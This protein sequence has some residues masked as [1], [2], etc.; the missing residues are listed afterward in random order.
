M[1][2]RKA[3]LIG[4]SGLVGGYCLEYLLAEELYEEV[5]L[6]V[7]KPVPVAHEKTIQRVTD[8]DQLEQL[9]DF[10]RVD[11][12]FCCLGSTLK[13]A[14]SQQA[15]YKVDF[16]YP[17][18][19]AQRA[20]QSGASQF[21]LVSAL[22]ANP[23]SEIFY[24]RVKGEVEAAVKQIPF[25]SVQIFRPSLLM[26]ARAEKRLGE[27]LSMALF[28]PLAW[29]LAGPWRKYRPIEAR[30]VA[31]AMVRVARQSLG[32]FNVYESDRIQ[33]LYDELSGFDI[34]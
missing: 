12:V 29:L 22:G 27:Q 30:A 20:F 5:V 1:T 11:D 16:S 10:P 2:K 28:R 21:L 31:G 25:D 4:A 7:R 14:G 18:E 3:L 6:L 13:K 15:F 19:L 26:G 24:N 8:F 23:R 9:R 32:G 33:T 34:H 17:A